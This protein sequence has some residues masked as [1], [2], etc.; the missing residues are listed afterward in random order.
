[1][2]AF[3]VDPRRGDLD[4]GVQAPPMRMALAQPL[5]VAADETAALFDAAEVGFGMGLAGLAQF[6]IGE[7]EP[8]I[9]VERALVAFEG[10]NIVGLSV[11]DP[12][13]YFALRAHRHH[14]EPVEGRC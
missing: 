12:G 10:K 9:V 4:D 11:D 8:D 6:G 1:M 3:L 14:P 2:A 5:D 7:E 13:G